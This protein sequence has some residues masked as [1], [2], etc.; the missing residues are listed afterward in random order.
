MV[1]K[2]ADN[3]GSRGFAICHS[4]EELEAAYERAL[5]FSKSKRVIIEEYLEGREITL[6][7]TVQEGKVILSTISERFHQPGLPQIPAATLFFP[8]Y[9]SFYDTR[10]HE[11]V[12]HL[13]KSLDMQNG[14]F[15]LQAYYTKEGF[16][17]MEI[18][19]RLSGIRQYV[20]V[21][22]ETRSISLRCT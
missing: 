10:M 21:S 6:Y 15:I 11:S 9:L 14:S 18:I 3:S 22:H 5:T 8:E 20:I 16:K 4:R 17:C 19:H 12:C 2:P 1:V 13:V 7:Y